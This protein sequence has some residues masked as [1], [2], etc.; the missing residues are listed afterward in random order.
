MILTDIYSTYCFDSLE[1]SKDF[2]ESVSKTSPVPIFQF[3]T[4]EAVNKPI[5]GKGIDTAS[6]ILSDYPL[7][8]RSELL[9][10]SKKKDFV[11]KVNY[12]AGHLNRWTLFIEDELFQARGWLN[13]LIPFF[14][15]LIS[16]Y[17]CVFIG[18]DESESIMAKHSIDEMADYGKIRTI[19]E[20]LTDIK[21][22]PGIYWLTFFHNKLLEKHPL[23][24]TS[25]YFNI[26]SSER[27]AFIQLTETVF[28]DLNKKEE[29]AT[30]LA[31]NLPADLVFNKKKYKADEPFRLGILVSQSRLYDPYKKFIPYIDTGE[32]VEKVRVEKNDD[33]SKAHASRSNSQAT[34]QYESIGKVKDIDE[35]FD[36]MRSFLKKNK[37]PGAEWHTFILMAGQKLGD[38]VIKE[39]KGKWQTRTPEEMSSVVLKKLSPKEFSPF[40]LIAQVLYNGLI[41]EDFYDELKFYY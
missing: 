15:K 29:L 3:G 16:T 27:G 28:T 14:E 1:K 39:G 18:T 35:L 10:K 11:L 24:K 31:R 37:T 26:H 21:Q 40:N 9:L 30:Q 2:I 33:N 32:F 6:R 25:A 17:E 20:G 7:F 8:S 4:S 36:S 22:L 5:A 12:R 38:M 34:T 19:Y 23:N 41:P 13:K